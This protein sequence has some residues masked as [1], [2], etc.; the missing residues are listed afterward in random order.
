M[1]VIVVVRSF[2]F[3]TPVMPRKPRLACGVSFWFYVKVDKPAL[4]VARFLCVRPAVLTPHPSGGTM[5]LAFSR[6]WD[7]MFGKKEMRIL[8]VNMLC[9]SQ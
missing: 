9:S 2:F 6:L 3:C 4:P 5:G 7:R 1:L 8:M